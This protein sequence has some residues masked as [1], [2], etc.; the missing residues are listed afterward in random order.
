MDNDDRFK[1]EWQDFEKRFQHQMNHS[2]EKLEG[3]PP[4]TRAKIEDKIRDRFR[5]H[6]KA[7]AELEEKEP[8]FNN[9]STQG[10]H[11]SLNEFLH[12]DADTIAKEAHATQKAKDLADDVKSRGHGASRENDRER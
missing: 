5:Q 7:I 2:L 9:R 8:D 4:E 11:M 12:F 6:E 1:P 3:L 10:K